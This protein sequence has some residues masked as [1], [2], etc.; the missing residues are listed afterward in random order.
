MSTLEALDK[1]LN[2]EHRIIGRRQMQ[3]AAL[4]WAVANRTQLGSEL[5]DSLIAYLD[6]AFDELISKE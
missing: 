4:K 5:A 3:T 1:I 2:A 6:H